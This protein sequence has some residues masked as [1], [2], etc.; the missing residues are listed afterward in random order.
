VQLALPGAE[1]HLMLVARCSGPLVEAAIRRLEGIRHS[2]EDSWAVGMIPAAD[3][4]GSLAGARHNILA[5]AG[6]THQVAGNLVVEKAAASCGSALL[7][8][9][10]PNHASHHHSSP[11]STLTLS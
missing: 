3:R 1:V 8:P 4:Q 7:L 5:A 9:A 6:S 10:S 11:S 2:T